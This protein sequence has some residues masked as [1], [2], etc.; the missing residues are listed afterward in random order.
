MKRDLNQ[1]ISEEASVPKKTD[2]KISLPKTKS[3][4]ISTPKNQAV[5]DMKNCKKSKLMKFNKNALFH[6]ILSVPI[7][8]MLLVMFLFSDFLVEMFLQL[9]GRD[10]SSNALFVETFL[11]FA[12]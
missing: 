3:R 1:T 2:P 11:Q 6:E 10:F 9:F 8:A 4:E 5:F 12:W 7:L